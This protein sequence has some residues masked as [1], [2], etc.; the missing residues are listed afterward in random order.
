M[1]KRK[2]G[3]DSIDRLV[4]PLGFD[5]Y[6]NYL[7]GPHWERFSQSYRDAAEMPQSC[8]A[9]DSED[10]ILH[11]INY[12]HLGRETFADVIPVCT[13]CHFRLHKFQAKHRLSNARPDL[14]LQKMCDWTTAETNE[15]FRAFRRIWGQLPCPGPGAARPQQIPRQVNDYPKLSRDLTN[16][17]RY[18]AAGYTYAELA[19]MYKVDVRYVAGYIGK[20]KEYFS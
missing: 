7:K 19:R 18:V 15:R 5:T 9:C 20:Y 4:R 13:K 3:Q 11:H 1:G 17:R 6:A 10:F 16:F 14:A 2:G 8:L 12:N